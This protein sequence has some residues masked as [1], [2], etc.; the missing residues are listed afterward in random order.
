[1][2]KIHII[3]GLNPSNTIIEIDGLRAENIC[4]AEII[5][6]TDD[7]P[8]VLLTIVPDELTIEGNAEVTDK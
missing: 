5:L 6:T 2:K 4:R 7:I 1:M 3:A 8:K